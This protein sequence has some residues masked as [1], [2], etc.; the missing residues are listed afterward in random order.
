MHLKTVAF[1]GAKSIG[2]ECLKILLDKSRTGDYAVTALFTTTD[3]NADA[4]RKIIELAEV[5]KISIYNSI[6]DILGLSQFDY[7]ISVQ[8]HEIL[9]AQHLERAK[10][11]AVNLHI[12]PLPEYRGCNQFS[13]A[14]IEGRKE[15]GCT[16]HKM[17]TGIDSGD[18]IFECRFPIPENCFVSEL[19][20]ISYV[21]AR[22]LFEDKIPDILTGNYT[23]IPQNTLVAQRGTRTIYRKDIAQMKH[24]DLAWDKEKI[25]RH[26]RATLMPGFPP[27]Y[28][29][30]S[31]KKI[32]FISE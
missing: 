3:R 32:N 31:G 20:D 22:Q 17:D 14:I 15:F 28:F 13:M 9:K 2:L 11:L 7:I 18:I 24:I 5:N 21:A 4:N 23:L 29:M 8:Y 19:V 1:L 25:E 26:L 30:L 12:A 10:E 6:D 16:L 27:P